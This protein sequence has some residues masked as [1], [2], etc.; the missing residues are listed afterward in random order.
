MPQ[1][2]FVAVEGGER[3][4]SKLTRSIR[5]HA[6]RAGLQKAVRPSR[7]KAAEQ[8]LRCTKYGEERVLRFE[9]HGEMNTRRDGARPSIVSAELTTLELRTAKA[10]S[11]PKTSAQLPTYHIES[12]C[13]GS[14]DPFN[15]LP[16]TT[17]PEVDHLVRYFFFKFD[18]ITVDRRSSW[19]PYALQSA[20]MMHST[21][22]MTATVWRMECP[23]LEHS[24]HLEGIHQ[25]GDAMREIGVRLPCASSVRKDN[26]MTFLMFTMS[27]L[28]IVE[29]YDG[30]FK[31]AETHLR[32]V[33]NI[34]TSRGGPD[35]FK[36][37]VIL[38][39]SINLAD[40]QVATALGH[41]PIFSLF[42]TDNAHVPA[43]ILEQAQHLPLDRSIT[44][45]S[46]Y[47]HHRIFA[48]LRQ[49]L[50][51]HKSSMVSLAVV[52]TLLTV[53]DAA[54]LQHLYRDC[55]DVSDA[56]RRSHALVLAAHVFMYITLRQVPPK[57]PLLRRMCARLQSTLGL[58][59]HARDTWS[60]NRA[61][62]LWIAFVGLL[63]TGEGAET[64]PR[65]QWF[66]SL[67]QSIVQGYPQD[68]LPGNGSIQRTLSTFLWDEAHCQ[69]LLAGL[70]EY[71][72][73]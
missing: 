8:S 14:V 12:L 17:N 51:A 46:S 15:S 9:L 65:E 33:H 72:G 57:A 44:H 52:R 35:S 73:S 55:I 41:R 47:H 40:I 26:E 25:K 7:P 45:D 22:A 59:P 13:A 16:I 2:K 53:A 4:S 37:D 70:E 3:K 18:P 38:C 62:L 71:L 67:F 66:L 1:Y 50:L 21:L 24:I 64:S 42:H 27:T 19:F 23:S 60:G 32:A 34:F 28:A 6:I 5:S 63:G 49:L 29:A 56:S 36:D 48:L 10:P 30:D 31:A 11:A 39:K 68:F 69:P 61:A 54:I 20:P 58:A 43:S